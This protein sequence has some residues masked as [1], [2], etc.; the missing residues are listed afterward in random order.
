MGQARFIHLDLKGFGSLPRPFGRG[1]ELGLERAHGGLLLALAFGLGQFLGMAFSGVG[2]L[3]VVSTPLVNR[4]MGGDE[5][6]KGEKPMA[7]GPA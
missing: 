6:Q 1:L 7:T 3:G 4:V 2:A 5:R